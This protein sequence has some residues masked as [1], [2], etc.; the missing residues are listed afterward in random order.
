VTLLAFVACQAIVAVVAVV[1]A[2]GPDVM[3]IVGAAAGAVTIQR[4]VVDADWLPRRAT[5]VR[6]WLL[7]ESPV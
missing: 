6:A 3:V 1:S 2:G 5:I 4:T 7:T